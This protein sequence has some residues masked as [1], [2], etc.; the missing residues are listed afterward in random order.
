MTCSRYKTQIRFMSV[1]GKNFQCHR[2][3]STPSKTLSFLFLVKRENELSPINYGLGTRTGNLCA[4]SHRGGCFHSMG[5]WCDLP[6]RAPWAAG[7]RMNRCHLFGEPSACS[8]R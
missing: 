1:K 8:V 7:R 4:F 2:E 6:N 5:Q 3:G